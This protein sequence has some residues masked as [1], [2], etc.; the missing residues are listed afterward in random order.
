MGKA[1]KSRRHSAKMRAKQT[2]KKAKR[3]AYAARAGTSSKLKKIRQRNKARRSSEKHRHLVEDCGN[4][5]CRRCRPELNG[6]RWGG[7]L[8]PV[9][10][11]V[12]ISKQVEA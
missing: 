12:P 9:G 3:A 4:I 6:P 7:R 1:S 10:T 11:K 5:S 2:A 8:W